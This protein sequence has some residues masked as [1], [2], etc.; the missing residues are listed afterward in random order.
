MMNEEE[1]K[2]E[3]PTRRDE[4]STII[5]PVIIETVRGIKKEGFFWKKCMKKTKN[6]SN[7]FNDTASK[8]I[9]Y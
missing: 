3:K 4:T 2:K 8:S 7:T 6:Y 1:K 9:N 5:S